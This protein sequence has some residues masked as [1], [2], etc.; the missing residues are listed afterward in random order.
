MIKA[1]YICR[2]Y[3]ASVCCFGNSDI[4]RFESDYHSINSVVYACVCVGIKG[5]YLVFYYNLIIC[6]NIVNSTI[7]TPSVF[8]V[9]IHDMSSTG[10]AGQKTNNMPTA[11]K[12]K[13]S[14][15]Q[16]HSIR[17]NQGGYTVHLQSW[18]TF[19]C[20][21]RRGDKRH[22]S[23]VLERLEYCTSVIH[24]PYMMWVN[25]NFTAIHSNR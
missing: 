19:A 13:S 20:N 14:K 5:C 3:T 21:W 7:S 9:F 1:Q 16:T 15:K 12:M 24:R 22:F 25:K 6:Q 4:C 2:W 10:S 23:F 11:Y 18:C 8:I 17:L